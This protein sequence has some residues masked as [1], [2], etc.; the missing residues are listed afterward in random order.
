M[1]N[2]YLFRRYL[3]FA[4]ALFVNAMGIA[5]I[6]KAALG[7][8][9]ITSVTYVASMFTPLT[10]GQW[11]IV[12]KQVKEDLRMYLSQVVIT[13]F[14]GL[15]IDLCMYIIRDLNPVG[16]ISQ[17]ANLLI[18]CIIL[19]LGIALEVKANVAMMAGEYFVRVL[20]Q[21][22]RKDFGYMKLGFDW[23]LVAIAVALSLCFMGGLYG[24]R[25][26]T[27]IAALLVG[28][29]VHFVSPWYRFIDAWITD[30]AI[31]TAPT[32]TAS[33]PMP[34]TV[35]TIAREFG[36][37]GHLLGEMLAKR[38]GIRLYDK[39]FIHLAAQKS[40]IDETY[41]RR[42]EQSIPSFWLKCILT[43]G[44]ESSRQQSLSPDDVLFLAESNI[45]REQAAKEPC[46]IV[47]RC[48]DYILQDAPSLIKVFCYSGQ[49]SAYQRCT[50][51]YGIPADKARVEIARVNRNRI[52][53]YEYYTG[54]KWGDPHRYDLMLNTILKNRFSH[55][56]S[57]PYRHQRHPLACTLHLPFL[58]HATPTLR[59][60]GGRGATISGATS[61]ME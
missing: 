16:Y 29:I 21:R 9:P 3:L 50:T 47:G 35:I 10:M 15:C 58:L 24:V 52:A 60:C 51:K 55:V 2:K 37:G 1:L 44:N 46:I 40:G 8:S 18:G 49:E 30:K 43:D 25:E 26:G 6:T 42:N 39:E 7:T 56:T 34:H 32:D 36:S 48:A 31:Q 41:I 20:S 45:I 59:T 5:Y 22:F 53:H 33:T 54:E 14:F 17:V 38:L 13:F 4:I 28:P 27:V 12:L 23:S 11:T 19:A 57:L 61:R